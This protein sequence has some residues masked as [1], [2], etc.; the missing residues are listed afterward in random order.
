[1]RALETRAVLL[2]EDDEDARMLLA[3]GL[4]NHGAEV[5]SAATGEQ[6][7]VM[8]QQWSPDVLVSDL[9]LPGI[10]GLQLL[11]RA[12]EAHGMTRLPA[13]ALTGHGGQSHRDA[14]F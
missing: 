9:S 3:E 10:D 13:I 14:A 11:T 7:L 6:A 8:L 5:R 2:V 12:R 4:N 1:M